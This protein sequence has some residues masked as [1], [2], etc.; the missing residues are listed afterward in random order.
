MK[1]TIYFTV[2][3]NE[4]VQLHSPNYPNL[5]PKSIECIWLIKAPSGY[6][7]QFNLTQYTA[8]NYHPQQPDMRIWRSNFNTNVTCQNSR[9]ILE[10][11]I[12]FYD[13]N[14]TDVEILERFCHNLKQPEVVTSTTEQVIFFF[15]YFIFHMFFIYSI[16]SY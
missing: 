3:Q 5:Y 15:T 16:F 9:S 7:I 12:A 14:N 6:S 2:K 8:L 1:I 4:M 10:G 11:S 13:G